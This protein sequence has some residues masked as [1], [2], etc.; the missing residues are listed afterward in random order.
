MTEDP[1]GRV[2]EHRERVLAKCDE[3]GEIGPLDDGFRYFWIRNRGAMSAADLRV[4]ADELD[5]RNKDW[6]DQIDR[7][8]TMMDSTEELVRAAESADEQ[9]AT[10]Q[11]NRSFVACPDCTPLGARRGTGGRYRRQ[12]RRGGEWSQCPVC[13]GTGEI[14]HD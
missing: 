14:E 11:A 5:R 10:T 3:F 8:L 1:D 6:Q 12:G 13:E 9:P 7:E 2:K 4:I